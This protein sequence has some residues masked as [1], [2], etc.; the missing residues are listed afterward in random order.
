[1]PGNGDVDT[2]VSVARHMG[3]DVLCSGNTHR[4]EA[5]EEDNRFFVNPGSA[6]GAF[7]AYEMN[8]TPS[9]V[10][11]DINNDHITAYVYQLVND[12][13]N[14]TYTI[15]TRKFISNSLLSRKQMIID[16]I[17]PGSAGVSKKDIREKLA[18]MYKADVE[19]IFVFGFKIQ[20]G[21]GRSTGFALIYDNKEAALKLEPKFRLVRHGIGEGPKTSSKQR[22]EK[23][24][25][26]K[27]LRGT[28]K[29]KGA[30]KPKE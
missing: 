23:K 8:P 17:H 25:R 27:K 16:I 24:N 30:K 6:T 9:F 28:A 11:M 14:G 12:E 3:V 2:L 10:L 21:G 18:S 5:N 26:L 15:R 4:F 22:K 19:A 13:A 1:V 29:T 7:S 20:F